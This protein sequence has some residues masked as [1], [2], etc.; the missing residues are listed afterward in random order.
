MRRQDHAQ[1]PLLRRLIRR[2]PEPRMD[3]NARVQLIDVELSGPMRPLAGI[4]SPVVRIFVTAH[5]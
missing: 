4:D 5:G 2:L 1:Q 3:S